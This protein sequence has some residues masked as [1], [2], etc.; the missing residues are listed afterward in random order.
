M[1]IKFFYIKTYGCSANY[2]NSEIIKGLL[3][4]AGLELT[5]NPEIADILILNTCIVKGKVEN[6][7]KR[8][9]QDFQNFYPTKP[10]IIAGCMPEVREI[11]GNNVYLLG[12]HNFKNTLNL[13]KK[14]SENKPPKTT[15]YLGFKSEI[16]LN[17]PKMNKRKII[18]ITQ[19]SEGCNQSCNY[20]LTR[21]AKGKLFTYPESSI[22]KNIESDVK[23]GCKEIWITSQDNA[24]YPNLPGLLN[25]ICKIKGNFLIR[26]GMM[27]PNNILPILPVLIKAYQNEKIYK[28]LHIPIQSGSDKILK[29]MNRKYKIKQVEK[30]ISSFKQAF[31]DLTLATD[32]IVAYPGESEQDF[33]ASLNLLKQI[34]PDIVNVSRFWSMKPTPASKLKQIDINLAKKR[35][36]IL[37]DLH[38]KIALENNKTYLEKL[39]LKTKKIKVLVDDKL[40][41]SFLSRDSNYKLFI[42]N[43]LKTN[44]LGK[45]VKLDLNKV[46]VY[47]HYII[48]NRPLMHNNS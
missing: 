23:K 33:K 22:I 31:P 9:I 45:F 1:E 47:P 34:K 35:A 18:G 14:I 24:S 30:I 10:L 36:K 40:G 43:N 46:K 8:K 16:K 2:N 29:A 6:K 13:I 12:T 5:N 44:L 26:V 42:I 39:K 11:K 28:F 3:T 4:N 19:I 7:I 48:A 25:K 38:L 32:I 21:F 41:K 27:N 15:D 20:C 17:L 37:H